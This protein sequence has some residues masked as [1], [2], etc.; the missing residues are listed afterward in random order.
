MKVEDVKKV[1][2]I[3]CG[4]MGSTLLAAISPKYEMVAVEATDELAGMVIKKVS[5]CF[6]PFVKKGKMTEEQRDATVAKVKSTTKVEDLKDCQVI[7]DAVPDDLGLKGK[8]LSAAHE[9]CSPD[10]IFSTTSS[11]MSVTA[12][13]TASNRPDRFIG[14]HFCNPA[15]MMALV[16]VAPGL[17]TSDETFN[18]AMEFC[19]ALG[20]TPIKCKDAPGYIVNYLFFPFLI[21]AVKAFESGLATAEDI[22]TACKLGL[23]HPMGPF[24]LLDMF[25]MDGVPTSFGVMHERTNDVRFAVP[26]LLRQMNEAGY[27][28]RKSGKG[29]YDY[30]KKK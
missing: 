15:H 13:A 18:F 25:G 5:G 24:E 6:Y 21:S 9:V 2:V 26:H 11:I 7:I 8:M 16:E 22:D 30:S 29:F 10:V 27:Y 4:V 12:L 17:Q 28:G 1:G 19:R 14:M 3:G 20:K 23:G